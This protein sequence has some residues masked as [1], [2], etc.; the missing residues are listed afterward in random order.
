LSKSIERLPHTEAGAAT[1]H[2]VAGRRHRQ[3]LPQ[4]LPA[5]TAIPV[6]TYCK[7][8]LAK[9]LLHDEF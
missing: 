9:L 7:I 2:S 3:A 1:W 8:Y 4:F 6:K 5:E